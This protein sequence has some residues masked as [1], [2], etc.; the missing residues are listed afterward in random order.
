MAKTV[1]SGND[2]LVIN[3]RVLQDLTDGNVGV[4]SF[5]NSVASIK[6]GKNGNSLYALNTSGYQADLQLRVLRGSADDKFLLGLYNQQQNNFAGTVLLQGAF[7]K[8]LGD[9]AGNV[10]YDTYTVIGGVF[11]KAQSVTSNPEGNNEQNTT[12]YEIMFSNT[13]RALG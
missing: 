3:G 12:V 4:L 2:T 13:V 5:P 11:S 6:T 10:S 1:L 8:Q 9:G 7:V